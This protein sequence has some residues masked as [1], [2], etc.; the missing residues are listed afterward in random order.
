MEQAESPVA[1][2]FWNNPVSSDSIKLP[3]GKTY[4]LYNL[5]FYYAGRLA[6]FCKTIPQLNR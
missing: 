3:S 5:P 4:T 6:S 1:I 2:R